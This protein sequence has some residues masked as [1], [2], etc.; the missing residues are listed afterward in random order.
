M[1]VEMVVARPWVAIRDVAVRGCWAA[2]LA[3]THGS[4]LDD[5][6]DTQ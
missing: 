5:Q 2:D 3:S 1:D 6:G 4:M